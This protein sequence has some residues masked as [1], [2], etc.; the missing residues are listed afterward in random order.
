MKIEFDKLGQNQ[1]DNLKS[2]LLAYENKNPVSSESPAVLYI[3]LTQNCIGHC[4]FCKGKDYVYDPQ[5]NMSRE[6]IEAILENYAPHAV[7]IDLRGQ[8]ESLMLPDFEEHLARFSQWGAKLQL[9]TTLGCGTKKTLQSLVDHDVFISL[10]LDA[11]EKELYESLRPGINFDTVMDNLGFVCSAIEKKWGTL[12]DKI[13]IALIP[14]QG[15]NLDQVEKI[16]GIAERFRIPDIRVGPLHSSANDPNLLKFHRKQALST[17]RKC[18]ELSRKLKI[19]LQFASSPLKS[20]LIKEKTFDCCCH[21]WLFAFINYR[22]DIM[23]CDHLIAPFQN[24]YRIGNVR[25]D[26]KLAWNG[27][28]ARQQRLAHIKKNKDLLSPCLNCY[29]NLFRY[30]DHEHEIDPRFKKWLVT[31]DEMEGCLRSSGGISG[32]FRLMGKN[33]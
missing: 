17:L 12:K 10:S 27:P 21:P 11:A 22:G 2:A 31:A 9:Y 14:L 15:K 29:K 3:E 20:L 5:L 19:D 13:R 32:L 18:V 16:F 24:K 6:I 33:R 28:P 4:A 26:K 23:V 8:G 7:M 30:A 1:L 25:D